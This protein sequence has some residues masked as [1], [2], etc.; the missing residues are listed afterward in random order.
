MI[1]YPP[2]MIKKRTINHERY[3]GRDLESERDGGVLAA[4]ELSTEALPRTFI[5][6]TTHIVKQLN[7]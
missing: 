1:N 4:V 6:L 5:T 3:R 7:I 2:R